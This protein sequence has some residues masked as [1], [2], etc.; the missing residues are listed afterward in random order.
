[1][2]V[3]VEEHFASIGDRRVRYLETGSGWPVLLLHAFPLN[4]DLWAP[5][6]ERAPEGFRFIAPDVATRPGAETI[7]EMAADVLLMAEHL[8]IERAVIGGISMGGYVTFSAYRQAPE[9]FSGMLLANTRAAADTAD[10]RQMRDRLIALAREK[11]PSAIV[12]DMMPKLLGATSL[13]ERADVQAQV[14]RIAGSNTA[15]SIAGALMA[16]KSRAD[17][18]DMLERISCATLVI[19]GD[20]DAATPLDEVE[21]MQLRIPRSRFV[22]LHGAGHLSNLEAPEDFSRALTDFLVSRM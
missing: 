15:E 13:R 10:A 22:T 6:L 17:M 21:R 3:M 20:E 1:M 14:R 7:D 12:D 9:R 8:E 18:S 11:G 16:M 5:Q 19:G 4:A 2:R